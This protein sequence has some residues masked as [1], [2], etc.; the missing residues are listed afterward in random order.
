MLTQQ[1]Y[2]PR[3]S[4]SVRKIAAAF[5]LSVIVLFLSTSCSYSRSSPSSETVPLATPGAA[6]TSP[7]TPERLPSFTVADLNG[8]EISPATLKGKVALIDFWATWCPPCRKEIP[9]FNQLYAEYRNRGLFVVGLALDEKAVE[10]RNFM[11]RQPIDYPVALATPE[12]Q[13]QFGGIEVYPTA[14][15]IDREGRIIKK[16]LGYIYP[17]EFSQDVKALLGGQ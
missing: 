9:H 6:A 14:F 13:R 2:S 5:A 12:L 4:Q 3:R 1:R 15:L 17:D 10:V 7:Q 11:R 8:Q 16:Y